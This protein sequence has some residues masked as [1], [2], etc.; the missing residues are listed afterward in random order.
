[1]G[2]QVNISNGANRDKEIADVKDITKGTTPDGK[3]VDGSGYIKVGSTDGLVKIDYGTMSPEDK[4]ALL[5][6]NTGLAL[7][8]D[9]INAKDANGNN[10]KFLY[11]VTDSYK[12][13]TKDGLINS[14]AAPVIAPIS[15]A[16]IS[17][18]IN[19]GGRKGVYPP[20][21]DPYAPEKG[22]QGMVVM[23]QIW[24]Y[25]KNNI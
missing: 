3:A 5:K 8:D 22:Y 20:A 4:K 17:K 10:I 16:S 11:K 25:K 24:R 1:L 13:R 18:N 6:E 2:D 19:G 15:V 21:E 14:E 23:F 7:L 9:L 12:G